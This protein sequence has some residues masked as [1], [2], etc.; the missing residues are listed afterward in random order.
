MH[1]RDAIN[2]SA[3]HVW[4]AGQLLQGAAHLCGGRLPRYLPC[5]AWV[6]GVIHY[7]ECSI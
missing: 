5:L 1:A 6:E 3:R 7:S 2:T 4:Q